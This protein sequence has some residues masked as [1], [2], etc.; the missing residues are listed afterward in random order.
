MANDSG[1]SFRMAQVAMNMAGHYAN[2]TQT[3]NSFKL[4][5]QQAI[6]QAIEGVSQLML[7][8]RQVALEQERVGALTAEAKQRTEQLRIGNV[9]GRFKISPAGRLAAKKDALG[10]AESLKIA[11]AVKTNQAAKL[12]A[13]TAETKVDTIK[14]G[15]IFDAEGNLDFTKTRENINLLTEA[16]KAQTQS[17]I[18]TMRQNA[19][20]AILGS[21]TPNQRLPA[22][23][24]AFKGFLKT[25]NIQDVD[26]TIERDFAGQVLG[27]RLITQMHKALDAAGRTPGET[28][29]FMEQISK[30]DAANKTYLATKPSGDYARNMVL[31]GF[32]GGEGGGGLP[33]TF[34]AIAADLSG[35]VGDSFKRE[36]L[37]VDR[38][39]AE[40]TEKV[41]GSVGVQVGTLEEGAW[42]ARMARVRDPVKAMRGFHAIHNDL[43]KRREAEEAA[44]GTNAVVKSITKQRIARSGPVM[45]FASGIGERNAEDIEAELRKQ[46]GRT[47]GADIRSDVEAAVR[48]A[49]LGENA[50]LLEDEASYRRNYREFLGDLEGVYNS[51]FRRVYPGEEIRL[52]STVADTA[53]AVTPR[54]E[55]KR[56][57]AKADA[58]QA[59]RAQPTNETAPLVLRRPGEGGAGE[60]TEIVP[61]PESIDAALEQAGPDV[62]KQFEELTQ[63]ILRAQSLGDKQG[64]LD[65]QLEGMNLLR[66][67]GAF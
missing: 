25:Y 47:S 64:E 54:E 17:G 65:L 16:E 29:G 23:G 50:S 19:H 48:E 41:H 40:Y 35:A 61:A 59:Q 12:A 21:F 14:K 45:Q 30:I 44:S 42:Q 13:D 22:R 28:E 46:F 5:K 52:H 2:L 24:E 57:P 39:L 36:G 63:K 3:E 26:G 66:E 11:N 1:T 33:G 51:E 43:R 49:D 60:T 62:Q 15:A 6:S 4:A 58:Q 8:K 56:L 9:A 10:Q 55:P 34:P 53:S 18:A 67:I 32:G 7:R 20:V 31:R 38:A 37:N 27:G